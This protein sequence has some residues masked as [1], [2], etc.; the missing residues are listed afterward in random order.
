MRNVATLVLFLEQSSYLQKTQLSMLA[1]F[2]LTNL[3]GV[4][5]NIIKLVIPP[6]EENTAWI[7]LMPGA[8]KIYYAS[9]L[10]F[11]AFQSEGFVD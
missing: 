7:T 6:E 1:S 3:P 9:F 8:K 4:S 10:F 11:E 2:D 5:K